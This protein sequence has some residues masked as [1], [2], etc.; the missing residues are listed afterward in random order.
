M[1]G[2][3]YSAYNRLSFL[4]VPD[5]NATAFLTATGI[6]DPT[7]TS[8]IDTLCKDLKSAGIWD[9]LKAIYPFVGGTATT[10]KF[11]LKDP[12]DLDAAFRLAF[13]G[14]WTH[15]NT[16]AKGN[17]V[18]N[19]ATT[20]FNPSVNQ[21]SG[22]SVGFYTRTS[23]TSASTYPIAYIGNAT[24]NFNYVGGL[25]WQ[26]SYMGI[27]ATNIQ[28]QSGYLGFFQRGGASGT[29]TRRLNLLS[30][31]SNAQNYTAPN[32]VIQ[33]AISD[34]AFTHDCEYAFFAIGDFL[35]TTEQDNFYTRVQAFQTTL[36]RQV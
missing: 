11:N 35:T 2:Y 29:Q 26:D 6:T 17:G 9:K 10:H 12:R 16:G 15:A 36:N 24:P 34:S 27:L 4:S 1:Y 3:G 25:N 23:K 32:A 30:K 14:G 8:A 22:M 20:Y 18:N 28:N 13:S 31:G 33:I 7:I 5:A 19:Y 21:P